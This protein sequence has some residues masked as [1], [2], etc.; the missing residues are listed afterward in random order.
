MI[1][2]RR[3]LVLATLALVQFVIVTDTT[4][5]NVALP[6]IGAD[7]G[8]GT[9]GLTWVVNAYLLA[10]GGLMLMG[11]RLADLLGRRR[12]FLAGAVVFGMAS[13]G[14]ALAP[15]GR[16]LV[17]ARALQG[18]GEALA[19]PAALSILTLLFPAP[20]DRARALGIWG[21]LAGL[22]ATLG[23]T[24][25]GVLVTVWGWRAV[26]WVNVPFVLAAVVLLPVLL[27][28]APSGGGPP[29]ARRRV[30]LGG[31]LTL[32]AG[33]VAVVHGLI[34][35]Q[36]S[37]VTAP[38]VWAP[39]LLGA[40][41][42]TA[43]LLIERRHPDPLVPLS[44]FAHRTR[45]AANALSAL[46]VGPMASMFLLLTLYQQD[47][48][49][50]SALQTGLAYL[51]FCVVFVAAVFASVA[52]TSRV[53]IIRATGT[54]FAVAALGMV[55]LLRLDPAGGFWGQLLPA[56]LV[57]AVG[58]GL[59]MPPLQTAAMSGLSELDA[60]LGAGVQT[61]VQSLGNAVGVALALLVSVQVA[62]AAGGSAAA[63]AAGTR[64]AFAASA[65][66][67]AL[68]LVLTLVALRVPSEPDHALRPSSRAEVPQPLG[69]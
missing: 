42:L 31:P 25:S 51:P 11:G 38:T 2:E 66:A 16:T 36:H 37:A 67:L 15:D 19:S 53:G 1:A 69:R 60:G 68:G 54:A 41:L 55:L 59:A 3:W 29:A 43:F 62:Q 18:V 23:V 12:M 57:L 44:F 33:L 46:V 13:V 39:V 17:A 63:M 40:G 22:G 21:G 27:K 7:V 48:L 35:A 30:D 24:L 58:F 6:S 14:C 5:V 10:A 26:F 52:L 47:V 8:L 65:G 49:G 34:G 4:I 50:R 32:T 61:A 20:A 64:S 56:T 28:L 45:L 9:A